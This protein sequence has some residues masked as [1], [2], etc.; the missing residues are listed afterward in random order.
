MLSG[1][2]VGR[3]VRPDDRALVERAACRELELVAGGAARRAPTRRRACA[4][5]VCVTGSFGRSRNP[6]RFFG[7]GGRRV[8]HRRRRGDERNRQEHDGEEDEAGRTHR[9]QVSALGEAAA[10]PRTR[11]G[12]RDSARSS[13]RPAARTSA[14]SPGRPASWTEAG[15]PSSAG[16][17][18]SASAG[19]PRTLNGIVR[20]ISR[21]RTSRS[22]VP[23]APTRGATSGSVGVS[24]EV[25]PGEQLLEPRAVLL[26]ACARR[27]GL[28]VG[29]LQAAL[30]LDPH[31]LAVE[32]GV[33]GEQ[34][35]VDARDLVHEEAA[36]RPRAR[37]AATAVR[38]G[39]RSAASSTRARTSG[40]APS[41]H[42]TA[43]E[44]SSS[45]SSLRGS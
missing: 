13:S 42:A 18:G 20:L 40:S 17:H 39:K 14:S 7:V 30:D 2:G 3:D 35:G 33:L 31:V 9:L 28:G 26:A 41:S 22:P 27:V 25:E 4:R 1:L 36:D 34:L 37:A 45:E 8:L 5:S 24:D 43:T 44:S 15:S 19:Q 10:L 23:P 32:V 38:R 29:H 12:L 6:W 11:D 16:P 21:S